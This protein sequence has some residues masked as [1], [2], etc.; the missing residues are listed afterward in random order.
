MMHKTPP[1]EFSPPQLIG[2][3]L[4]WARYRV[5]TAAILRLQVGR[6]KEAARE[7]QVEQY[8]LALSSTQLRQL[9]LDLVNAA[10]ELDG[11]PPASA[12]RRW[13]SI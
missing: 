11:R 4:G 12:R 3:L 13:L 5:P 7:G 9:A 8:D 6:T 1:K 10:D 2:V